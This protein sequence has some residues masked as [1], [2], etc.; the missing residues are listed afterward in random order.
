MDKFV[1]IDGAMLKKCDQS[2]MNHLDQLV[3][4]NEG[5]GPVHYH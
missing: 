4:Q 5:P 3:R 2:T 1:G